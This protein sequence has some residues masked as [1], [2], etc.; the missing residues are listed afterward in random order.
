MTLTV[1]AVGAYGA[2][3]V[4]VATSGPH[5]GWVW[6]GTAD[7]GLHRV[8]PDGR[9]VQHLGSTGGRPL[10]LEWMPDGRLLVC[11]ARRGLLVGD[12]DG[13][14]VE[15]L[16]TE[17]EG[18]P[19][20]FCNNAAV[21]SDGTVY[22]S[23]SSTVHGV[24]T[25]KS[26]ILEL[27]GTGRLLRR[28]PDGEVD[29]L[30]GG[31]QFANGVALASDETWVVVAE[32]SVRR[33]QRVFVAGPRAGESEVYVESVPGFPDNIA[34]GSDGLVWVTL[35]SPPDPLVERL[36]RGPLWLRSQ[37]TRLPERMQPAP[38][39]TIRVQAYDDDGHL[40]HD[41]AL[42][43]PADTGRFHMPTGVREHDGRVWMGS[44][45]E[46]AVAVVDLGTPRG[47]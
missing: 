13:A 30:L 10:G 42:T 3:D 4:L 24:D 29:V 28:R 27:T 21:A 44:L 20:T 14:A 23:D 36:Q 26:E 17:V 11:D 19:F 32:T 31:L 6:T 22:V 33:L 43:A 35:A 34:R 1:V 9:Q 25:W 18:R 16:L 38:R 5:E 45:H 8:S 15:P 2:E 39:R 12:P 47:A 7:G 41:V 37:V 46:D 40:V